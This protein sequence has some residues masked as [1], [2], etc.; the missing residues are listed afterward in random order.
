M[1]EKLYCCKWLQP[2]RPLLHLFSRAS[3]KWATCIK[4]K[5]RDMY[6]APIGIDPTANPSNFFPVW[7][8]EVLRCWLV[9]IIFIEAT[10]YDS[11]GNVHLDFYIQG[12]ALANL[13]GISSFVASLVFNSGGQAITILWKNMESMLLKNWTGH[14]TSDSSSWT[15]TLSWHAS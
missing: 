8:A 6:Q 5:E 3:S 7:C 11:G 4:R 1:V 14:W 9:I 10:A 2:S 12:V 15:N 13:A